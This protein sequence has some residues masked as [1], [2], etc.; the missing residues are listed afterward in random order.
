MKKVH[1]ETGTD[2]FYGAWWKCKNKSDAAMI[3][4]LGDDPEDH[5][6]RSGVRW[7]HELGGKRH[8][9]VSGQK[10]LRAS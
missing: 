10:R 7:L 1:F 5:M 3:L 4:M 6:A 8:V 9:N 2:G